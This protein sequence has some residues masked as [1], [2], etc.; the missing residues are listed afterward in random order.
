MESECEQ[1]SEKFEKSS[2][3]KLME[4]KLSKV[5]KSF[6][7]E[8]LISKSND[9]DEMQDNSSHLRNL[10]P[11]AFPQN[12]PFYPPWAA[13]YLMSQANLTPNLL[14]NNPQ[15]FYQLQSE[16]FNLIDSQNNSSGLKEILFNPNLM[17]E[18]VGNFLP[19]R[20]HIQ[21]KF[22]DSN[23]ISEFYNNYFMM[24]GS[25]LSGD[26]NF[27]SRTMKRSQESVSS[28]NC[29]ND[30]SSDFDVV[31]DEQSEVGVKENHKDFGEEDS[32]FSHSDVSVTMSPN[33][34][35]KSS[36]NINTTN[37]GESL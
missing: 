2:T 35:E 26:N 16:K 23:F 37:K 19:S 29:N 15:Q 22:R 11:I 4:T 8:N 21:Q 7:I 25:R 24:E 18:H 30:S 1:F 14:L 33:Q 17:H 6:S 12:F 27:K 3:E 20:D 31:N 13:N 10:P 5:P 34:M 28:E 32:S 36:G 9:N